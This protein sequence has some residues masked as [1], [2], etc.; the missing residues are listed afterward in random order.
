MAIARS[1]FDLT[2]VFPDLSSGRHEIA[3]SNSYRGDISVYLANA[4]RPQS[5]RIAIASQHRD[6][7]QQ[8]LAIDF[9]I[10]SGPFATLPIWLFGTGAVAWLVLRRRLVVATAR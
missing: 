4:L 9:T 7:D 1:S 3:F 5:D 2:A 6:Q 8:R 10:D